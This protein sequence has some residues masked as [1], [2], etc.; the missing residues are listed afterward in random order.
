M[1]KSLNYV[2]FSAAWHSNDGD[3]VEADNELVAEDGLG[4]ETGHGPLAQVADHGVLLE[5]HLHR[6]AE[7]CL[8]PELI[9][10]RRLRFLV[11]APEVEGE[12]SPGA[13]E[14]HVGCQL[15]AVLIRRD[16]RSVHADDVADTLAHRQVVKLVCEENDSDVVKNALTVDAVGHVDNLKGA[17]ILLGL[18]GL[19]R[20]SGV[21]DH[22]VKVDIVA[23]L[24]LV[25]TLV[26]VAA[27]LVFFLYRR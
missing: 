22:G 21:D 17:Q 13:V 10:N 3:L 5:L 25:Q 12:E 11:L 9:L 19:V 23:N 20:E 8:R 27:L 4:G 2:G 15:L 6:L 18:E 1:S 14:A 7:E 26:R 24:A 16:G